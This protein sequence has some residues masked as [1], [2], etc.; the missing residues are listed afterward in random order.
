MPRARSHGFR[1][2]NSSAAGIADGAGLA[3][4]TTCIRQPASCPAASGA[5]DIEFGYTSTNIGYAHAYYPEV[6]SVYFNATEPSLVNTAVGEYGFQTFVHEIGHALGLNHMGDYNGDGNWSPSSYQDSVVLSVMS[7]FGPRSAAPNYSAEVMQADWVDRNGQI[8]SPQTPMVNDVMAI[9]AMYGAST[10]TR[11]GDTVYG[12]N[13]NVGRLH[14]V[15]LQLRD[16]PLPGADAV[17]QRWHRHAGPERLVHAQPCGPGPG[18]L[19]G[20]QR[21]DE[22]HRHR[23]RHHDR[24]RGRRQRQRCAERQRRG[25]PAGGRRR[26]RPARRWRR[27][28]HARRRRRQRH[29]RRWRRQRHRA[30]SGPPSAPS[31]SRSAA[32][33]SPWCRPPPEPTAWSASR[34]SSSATWRARWPN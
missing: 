31:R 21:D 2:L 9:Q 5:S 11:S 30:C 22:Q 33:P 16:Q 25:Q 6:G 32:T 4:G 28:R 3:P 29:D 13:T 34:P 12:F 26:Q 27:Q 15:D 8:H 17:R 18:R 1:A 20:R 24:E 23:V 14:G 19:L 7:Y 10:T